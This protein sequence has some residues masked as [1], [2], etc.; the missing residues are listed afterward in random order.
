[1]YAFG[2]DIFT[3]TER[4]TIEGVVA[5][6]FFFGPAAASF[7]YCVSFLFTSASLCNICIIMTGFLTG[8]GAPIATY[9]LRLIGSESEVP[10]EKLLRTASAIEWVGRL[11]PSF[12]LG[13]G[14]L[15]T[16]YIRTFEMRRQEELSVFDKDILLFEVIALFLQS[17]GYLLLAI[18]LDKLHTKIELKLSWNFVKSFLT[19]KFGTTYEACSTEDDTPEDDDVLE[20]EERVIS[21]DA[22]S[23]AV[24][25]RELRKVYDNGKVAVNDLSL[26]IPSGECFGLLGTNGTPFGSFSGLPSAIS[27]KDALNHFCR[28]ILT[29]AGK[30]TT[31]GILTGEFPPSGGDVLLAG[32]SSVRYPEHLRSEIGYCP[33]FDALYENLSGRDHVELYARIKGIPPKHV[34]RAAD[35][36]LSE[37]GFNN[38]DKDRL[39]QHYSG[40]MKRK[41]SIACAT[42]S[43]P[44]VVCLDEPSTG[45]D[46]V[47]RREIWRVISALI[48]K[49]NPKTNRKTCAILTTHSMNECESLCSRIGIM[50]SGKLL[51]LG[52]AQRLK[53]KY[54]RGYQLEFKVAAVVTYDGDYCSVR[55]QLLSLHNADASIFDVEEG[56]LHEEDPVFDLLQTK[57]ALL[58]LPGNMS[59]SNL[60]TDNPFSS[61]IFKDAS[62]AHGVSL[63]TLAS[64]VTLELRMKALHSFIVSSYDGAILRERQDMKTRYEIDSNNVVLADI[65]ERIEAHKSQLKLSEYGVSQTS[66]EL[67]FNTLVSEK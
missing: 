19:C 44:L 39:S 34:R 10:W 28:I 8:L 51:C 57:Q 22:D 46:P 4:N 64:F 6:L 48:S 50:K 62:S 13:K 17:L 11:V 67:V 14:L 38:C 56:P 21:G 18:V 60:V 15:Y 42:I 65:F 1:M 49:R 30:T 63:S 58:L 26:G 2:V 61:G 35:K 24:V 37:V 36:K 7:A 40:G 43:N 31:L 23:D 32:R 27:L 25:L 55:E 52:S 47:A 16:I 54:G 41:L 20:E 9:M 45:V 59:L 29:G 3:T 5:L 12:C 66:L 33:Q 53:S